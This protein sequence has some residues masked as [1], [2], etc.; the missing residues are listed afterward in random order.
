MDFVKI[1]SF[2]HL[3]EK[4]SVEKLFYIQNKKVGIYLFTKKKQI[5]FIFLLKKY[6][7]IYIFRSLSTKIY[8]K[9]K[10]Y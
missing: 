6:K 7:Q 5:L 3:N 10:N 9:K 8:I 2:L 4:F 1:F